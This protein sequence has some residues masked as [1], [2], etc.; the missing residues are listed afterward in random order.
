MTQADKDRLP[1][2]IPSKP[3][4][5]PEKGDQGPSIG[6]TIHHRVGDV[7]PVKIKRD[8]NKV[9]VF[10]KRLMQPGKEGSEQNP[11]V[12]NI[13]RPDT[14]PQSSSLTD[15]L[16][17]V[18]P[19]RT[20]FN[21]FQPTCLSAVPSPLRRGPGPPQPYPMVTQEYPPRQKPTMNMDDHFFVTN[22]HID[23]VAC[24][25]WDK[26]AAQAKQQT[27]DSSAKHDKLMSL[28][29]QQFDELKSQISSMNDK[30]DHSATQAHNLN[31]QLNKV[32]E[33]IRKEV[34]NSVE[35]QTKR[36]ADVEHSVK[37]LQ[38][39]MQDLQKLTERNHAVG[40]TIPQSAMNDL[41]LPNH[42]SQP[43]LASYYDGLAREPMPHQ[44]Q[45]HGYVEGQR[46]G[47]SNYLPRHGYAGREG[48]DGE[49]P[50][51]RTN[52]YYTPSAPGTGGFPPGVQHQY[53]YSPNQEYQQYQN[54]QQHQ[55]YGSNQ[56]PAKMSGC[57]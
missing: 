52:P 35:V 1:F 17:S 53:G 36:M 7:F 49:N 29:D 26:I 25:L 8:E 21:D 39:A 55:H 18:S 32:M 14:R 56:G 51:S 31:L 9:P 28:V 20:G 33:V 13:T 24:T 16:G 23:V 22:E 34:V 2:A 42:H 37:E 3:S 15:M 19:T 27:D 45:A 44:Q 48:K 47:N 12:N 54:L 5:S 46:S 11:Y 38:K 57:D 6:K 43:S 41:P 40:H 30:A 50:F 10:A 4:Q